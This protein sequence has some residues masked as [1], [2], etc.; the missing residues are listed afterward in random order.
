VTPVSNF[1]L[2]VLTAPGNPFNTIADVLTF[3]KEHPGDLNIGTVSVGSTQFLAAK[4]FTSVAGID[5]VVIPYKQTPELMGAVARG[6]VDIAFEIVPG[7]MSAITNG[8][9]RPIAT[10]N[11]KRSP[12][13][14]D[15]PTVEE[16][17]VAPY[18]VS[19]WNG[20]SAPK[21]VPEEVKAK[22]NAAVTKVLQNPEVIAKLA[23]MGVEPYIASPAEMAARQEHEKAMWH[24]VIIAAG[25][26]IE[27]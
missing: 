3:A 16:A 27:N 19:S 13:Y 15:L 12:L 26:P 21:G 14:P 2:A 11:A 24:D 20:W 8:Q 17:G 18:D 25:V 9:V 23:A 4:L 10:T 5:A 22:L 7:A 1:G 6:E